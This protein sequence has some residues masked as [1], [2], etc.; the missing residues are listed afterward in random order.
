MPGPG[1]MGALGWQRSLL[2]LLCCSLLLWSGRCLADEPETTSGLVL[3]LLRGHSDTVRALRS[4]QAQATPS[5]PLTEWVCLWVSLLCVCQ[6][7]CEGGGSLNPS[8]SLLL[9]LSLCL[10]PPPSTSFTEALLLNIALPLPSSLGVP[11][12]QPLP[13][14]PP[15]HACE[16][17][18]SNEESVLAKPLEV[19]L[20]LCTLFPPPA[21]GSRVPQTGRESAVPH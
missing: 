17:Q 2:P 8:R 18:R 6:C 13:L 11:Y 16:T 7:G 15:L 9:L 21:L 20:G 3:R 1:Q 4:C 19:T 10:S 5:A 14:T 12:P